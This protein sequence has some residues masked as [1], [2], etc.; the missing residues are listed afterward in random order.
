MGNTESAKLRKNQKNVLRQMEKEAQKTNPSK[1]KDVL[2][3][4]KSNAAQL[5]V[6]RNFHDALTT[7]TEGTVHVTNF[8]NVAEGKQ[9]PK[10]LAWLNELNSVVLICIT[11]DS[12]ELFRNIIVEK[13][14]ADQ[15]GYLHPKVFS[16]TFGEKLTE[17]PPKG[18]KKGA[19]DLRDFHF[20]F[21]DV[22]KIRPQDF[23]KSFRLNSLIAAIKL[24][25]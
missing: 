20:G 8:V 3:L 11:S 18:L 24:T 7:N 15:N 22:E 17:W 1:I 5:R 2:F 13:G 6:V 21:S 25:H 4:H 9:V 12:I 14:F 10:T 19:T 23:G 16:V